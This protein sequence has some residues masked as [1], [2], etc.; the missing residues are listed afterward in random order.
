MCKI[1]KCSGYKKKCQE[2][3]QGGDLKLGSLPLFK[4][5]WPLRCAEQSAFIEIEEAS[6]F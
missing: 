4:I 1:I 3:N 6:L 2:P 5:Q